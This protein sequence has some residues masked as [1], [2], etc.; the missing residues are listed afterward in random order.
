LR[1][2][3]EKHGVVVD[4]ELPTKEVSEARDEEKENIEAQ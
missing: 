2:F 1:H 3:G 4:L